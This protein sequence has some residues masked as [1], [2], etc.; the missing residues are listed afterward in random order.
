MFISCIGDGATTPLWLDYWLLD[1]KQFCD[2]LS[3][4]VLHSS[5]L[6]WDAKVLDIIKEGS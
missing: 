2:L 6:T 3:F 5:R 1:E 4:R